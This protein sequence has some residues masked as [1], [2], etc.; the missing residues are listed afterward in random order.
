MIFC[1]GHI[2]SVNRIMEALKYFGSVSSLQVNNEKS[3]MFIFGMTYESREELIEAAGF[4]Q[5]D[6]SIKYLGVSLSTRKW[7]Q[8]DY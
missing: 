3:H 5:G 4:Q 1:K 7:N 2:K 8:N 6:F